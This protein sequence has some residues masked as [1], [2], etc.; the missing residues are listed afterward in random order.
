MKE[1][2]RHFTIISH[3][4]DA[5][6]NSND[7]PLHT[8]WDALEEIRLTVANAGK[9]AEQPEPSSLVGG[10][11]KQSGGVLQACPMTQ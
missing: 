11:M 7:I 3:Q 2:G 5:N 1:L 6:S 9:D 10:G 4:G 8:H